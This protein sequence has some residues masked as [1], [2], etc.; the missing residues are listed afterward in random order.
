MLTVQQIYTA[1]HKVSVPLLEPKQ[2]TAPVSNTSDYKYAIF[3]SDA[4]FNKTHQAKSKYSDDFMSF[5]S[6]LPVFQCCYAVYTLVFVHQMRRKTAVIFY[7]WLPAD[8]PAEEK[9]RYSANAPLMAK[10]LS[11]YDFHFECTEWRE[12]QQSVA[13]SKICQLLGP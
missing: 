10:Q 9:Q 5:R 8:A 7:T 2:A 4:A 11:H 1:P 6:S 12:F 13:I 3:C